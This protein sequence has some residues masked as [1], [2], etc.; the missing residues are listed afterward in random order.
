M[1]MPHDAQPT[2][3]DWEHLEKFRRQQ[4]LDPDRVRR[5]Q[6][7]LYQSHEPLGEALRRLG[8]A[9]EAAAS[10]FCL[11]P[12]EITQRHA[13]TLDQSIK[14]VLSTVDGERIE[15]VVLRAPSGRAAV[16]VSTQVG[17]RAGCAFCATARMGLRRNL[18]AAEI[19]EQVMVAARE[20][21]SSHQRLRNVVFMGMG[22]PLDN[23]QA[24]HTALDCL[25]HPAACR[26]PARR[27]SVST[28]GIPDAMERLIA[29]FPGIQV[30]LSL[31]SARSEVR[32]RLIPWAR[33]V[34]LDDLRRA[35]A[36][37]AAV[38][39]T[40]RHQGPVRIEYIMIAGVTDTDE[41]VQA[42]VEYLRG[43]TVHVNLIPYNPVPG[44]LNWEPSARLRRDQFAGILRAAGI[45]TTIRYSMGAD[46][47]AACGQL[48]QDAR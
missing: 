24:L 32:R 46:I 5:M 16:C 21:K 30:A 19:I 18:S 34:E 1:A 40:H 6:Y 28:V 35:L 11:S 41:D 33:R 13:S 38:P 9:A 43:L 12:L 3:H 47:R 37:V 2:L 23:E 4:R 8:S 10:H 45:F 39:Q 36:A 20:L 31:H 15:T 44:I 26:I 27:L 17:C 7:A 25:Q 48:A 29:R 14:F 42:V 22:E